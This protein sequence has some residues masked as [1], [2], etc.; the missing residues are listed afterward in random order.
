[1]IN[2]TKLLLLL[3]LF[4][5]CLTF[6]EN[7]VPYT[8]TKSQDFKSFYDTDRVYI[9]PFLKD[10]TKYIVAEEKTGYI[11]PKFIKRSWHTC[12]IYYLMENKTCNKSIKFEIKTML[13]DCLNNKYAILYAKEYDE[14]GKLIYSGNFESIVSR[15]TSKKWFDVKPDSLIV[16]KFTQIC[17]AY[18]DK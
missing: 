4:V 13:Y 2:F 18:N 17:N 5:S 15:K 14:T 16:E 9:V 3:S 6:A 12:D 7:W 1:M 11:N 8:I 10:N